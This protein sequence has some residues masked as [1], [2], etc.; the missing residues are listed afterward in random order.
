MLI[1]HIV[2][3]YELESALSFL[4]LI[5]LL[6]SLFRSLIITGCVLCRSVLSK[7]WNRTIRTYSK[8]E[9]NA[10]WT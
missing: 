3:V 2:M 7:S 4:L 9:I 5:K 6:Q 1:S 10:T 8:Q